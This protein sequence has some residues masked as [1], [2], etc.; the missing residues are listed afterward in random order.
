[1]ARIA[2]GG[3]PMNVSPAAR[4][5]SAKA[6]FSARKPVDDEVALGGGSGTDGHRLVGGQ[7]VERFAIDVGEDR[8]G[9]DAQLAA[10]PDHPDG[11]LAAIGDE[12]LSERGAHDPRIIAGVAPAGQRP[13][14]RPF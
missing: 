13:N 12:D 6:A 5:A 7:D 4:Q 10:G 9:G 1:M 3:G 2:V 14:P 8:D 11:D